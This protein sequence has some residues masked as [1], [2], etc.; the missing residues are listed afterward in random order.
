MPSS[1]I[2]HEKRNIMS[3]PIT[4]KLE[5]FNDILKIPKARRGVFLEE[6][7]MALD[8]AEEQKPASVLLTMTWIDDGLPETVVTLNDTEVWRGQLH[9]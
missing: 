7:G 1:C 9:G 2:Q 6:L 3:E 8:I 5:S 4:Y